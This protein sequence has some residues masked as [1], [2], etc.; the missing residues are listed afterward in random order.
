MMEESGGEFGEGREAARAAPAAEAGTAPSATTNRSVTNSGS[1][2]APG[3]CVC[4][5]HTHFQRST[6][7]SCQQPKDVGHAPCQ[8]MNEVDSALQSWERSLHRI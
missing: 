5:S 8:F 6:M 3:D 2:T 7:Q 1:T 4:S